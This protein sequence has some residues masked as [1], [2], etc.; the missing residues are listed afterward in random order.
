M[1]ERRSV[2]FLS[3]SRGAAAVLG[4]GILAAAALVL[5][6]AHGAT[7]AVDE[8]YY[9]GRVAVREG[10]L[11]HYPSA[12]DPHYLLAPFNGHL[13]LGGRFIYELV[14][15]TLG[16]NYT[17]FLLIDFTGIALSAILVFTLIHRRIGTPAALAPCLLLLFLGFAR[18]QFLWPIDFNSS[19]ALA[20]GLGA[21][22]ALQ[23]QDLR[24]DL[25]GFVLLSISAA[26]IEV[27]VAFGVGIAVMILIQPSR[28]RRLWIV[29]VPAVLYAAWWLW[30]TP[31]FGGSETELSNI[32]LVPKAFL[33]GLGG[34]LGALTGTNP[35][36]PGSTGGEVTWFGGG[37][38]I[39]AALA[40]A[41][42]IR[43]GSLPISGSRYR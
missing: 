7:F 25:L 19:L 18:E 43:I 28:W 27:G 31:R 30:A 34:T 41:V 38:A 23:R 16:A 22:L 20:T 10:G 36:V 14:F 37:L 13:A 15:A 32:V 9:Y 39:L 11:I 8:L 21:V 26:M 3:E 17:V 6:T 2:G 42:R 40:L 35:V 29:I 24:G 12:F 4:A 5:Y 1:S 33:H